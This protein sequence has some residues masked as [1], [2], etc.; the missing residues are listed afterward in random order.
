YHPAATFFVRVKGDSMEGA[1]IRDGDLLVVDRALEP[2]HGRIV[3]AVVNGELTVKRLALRE[4]EAWLEPENPAYAPLKLTEGL[5]CIVWGV[6][7]HVI[8]AV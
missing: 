4:G 6:V 1:G 2:G 5:D 7:K 3:I 8:H